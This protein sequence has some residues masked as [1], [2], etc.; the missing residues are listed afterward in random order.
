MSVRDFITLLVGSMGLA[1]LLL[2]A[3]AFWMGRVVERRRTRA[4]LEY[5]ARR[6]FLFGRVSERGEASEAEYP[7]ILETGTDGR[8][9]R[10][11]R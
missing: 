10:L 5:H 8:R 1:T 3:A 2:I 7:A 11:E 6:G 9:R 4:L